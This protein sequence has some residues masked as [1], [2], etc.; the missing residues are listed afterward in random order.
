MKAQPEKFLDSESCPSIEWRRL[1]FL[2]LYTREERDR[3]SDVGGENGRGSSAIVGDVKDLPWDGVLPTR[4]ITI[5][6]RFVIPPTL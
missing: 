6:Y 3:R 5:Y 1:V 4:D 2:H